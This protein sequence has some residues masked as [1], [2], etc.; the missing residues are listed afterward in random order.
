MRVF[1]LTGGIASGKSLVAE[2]L[3]GLGAVIV[4]ADV[5]SRE[6]VAVGSRGLDAIRATF[7]DGVIA[8]DGTLDRAAM[9]AIV[10][11]DP[12]ARARLNAIVHPEVRRLG[13][14]RVAAAAAVDPDAIVVYDIPLLVEAGP[15]RREGFDG[16]IVV[17]ADEAERVRRMVEHR[18]MTEQDAL[19]RIA[20]Q[21]TD[22]QRLA[23]ATHHI[24]NS[25]ATTRTIEA[26]DRLWRELAG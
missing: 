11:A 3:A 23:I 18:G 2:R 8:A 4:D 17:T 16:V 20:A 15:A 10:F 5:L 19:A 14:E 25:G 26:V 6:A 12:E 21:A 7:G 1:G 24:D 9:G 22:E 13:E